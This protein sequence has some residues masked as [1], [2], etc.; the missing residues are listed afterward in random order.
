MQLLHHMCIDILATLPAHLM[1]WSL[2]AALVALVLGSGSGL[3]EGRTLKALQEGDWR[4]LQVVHKKMLTVFQM[5]GVGVGGCHCLPQGSGKSQGV[6][7]RADQ[8]GRRGASLPGTGDAARDMCLRQPAGLGGECGLCAAA[9]AESAA[10][11]GGQGPGLW[12]S[13]HTTSGINALGNEAA[14][15]DAGAACSAAAAD[16]WCAVRGVHL[17]DKGDY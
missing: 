4:L 16:R 17:I 11:A 9:G 8:W 6:G 10:A 14:A 1:H 7:K 15:R 2:S 12:C 5:T 13:L 3:R